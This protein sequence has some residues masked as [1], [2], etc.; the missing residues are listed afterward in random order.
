MDFK[1]LT[2]LLH[3]REPTKEEVT[4]LYIKN[5]RSY[6]FGTSA[7]GKLVNE[8]TAMRPGGIDRAAPAERL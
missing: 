5:D 2:R 8:F 1:F 4:D 7:S 3:P 6:L